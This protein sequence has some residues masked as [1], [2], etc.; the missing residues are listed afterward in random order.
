MRSRPSEPVSSEREM[1]S[2]VPNASQEMAFEPL[3]GT[4]EANVDEKG[5][6]RLSMKAVKDAPQSS[7]QP[8]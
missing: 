5:R 4:E 2:D 6:V 7:A 1:I 8:S 3:V